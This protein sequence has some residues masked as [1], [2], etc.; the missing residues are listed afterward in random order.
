MDEFLGSLSQNSPE[1]AE[2][3]PK[4]PHDLDA[5]AWEA[6]ALLKGLTEEALGQ[7]YTLLR[8]DP[9]RNHDWGVGG[10]GSATSTVLSVTDWKADTSTNN[11]HHCQVAFTLF[12]RR[13]H[14]RLCGDIFCGKCTAISP[15]YPD[16][17]CPPC[18]AMAA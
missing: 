8:Q 12:L 4:M 2:A 5:K 18:K 1:I 14:C 15:D 17:S 10:A 3:R 9:M 13:H 16:R 6:R 7:Y 11:C